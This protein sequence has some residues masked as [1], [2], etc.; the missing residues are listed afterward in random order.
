MPAYKNEKRGTWFVS[1]HYKD[2]DGTP[3][4]KKK[5]GFK[6]KREALEW[7][8]DFLNAK[9]GTTDMTLGSL[10]EIYIE[11]CKKRL[12]QTTI[13]I[14][15]SMIESKILPTF[16]NTQVREIT[17]AMVR[18]W[19]NDL[20]DH[21]NKEGKGYAAT[22]LKEL[23]D[24]FSTMMNFAIRFYGLDKNPVTQCGPFGRLSSKD[25]QFWTQNEFRIAIAQVKNPVAKLAIELLFWTG[26]RSG[27]LLALTLE[28][29]D[30][31]KG[32]IS[33][34]KTLG[35]VRGGTII[36]PP[37]TPKSN[38]VI[39]VPR[40]MLQRI[41]DYTD[42]LVEYEPQDRIFNISKIVLKK[43][44]DA[45]AMAADIKRI[46]IHDLR[47]SHASMLIEMGYSPLV[48]SERLGH[49][50]IQTTLQTYSHLYPNK[51]KEL[52]KKLEDIETENNDVILLNFKKNDEECT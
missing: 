23:N 41:K 12:R 38:R 45:A 48:I 13:E 1:F 21:M 49:E 15:R 8:R 29:I 42:R 33:I 40:F 24:Q 46:R 28:D 9:A 32:T 27:E 5:E 16:R 14:K 19:Q 11:D 6:T 52:V 37:K 2:L 50:N 34:S 31:E 30:F 3:R 44:L 51:Q 36:N 17:P 26:M 7:E 4:R 39:P 43:E 47:H 25:M 18:H 10:Y 22:Y 35:S 20:L